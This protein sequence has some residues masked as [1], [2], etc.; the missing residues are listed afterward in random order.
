MVEH[1]RRQDSIERRVGTGQLLGKAWIELQGDLTTLSLSAGTRQGFRVGVDPNNLGSGIQPLD[2]DGQVACSATDF[3]D[4]M[5][6][7]D[8][9]L[10]DEFTVDCL[11]PKQPGKRVVEGKEPT[12]S[13]G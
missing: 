1:E 5:T 3:E 6:R 4:S 11:D 12:F 10:T 9:G 2:Q 13:R 7:A 8:S